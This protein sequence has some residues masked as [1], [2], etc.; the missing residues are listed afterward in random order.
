MDLVREVAY[1]SGVAELISRL[2]AR[3]LGIA[4]LPSAF[5]RPLAADDPELTLVPVIDGPH[6]VEYL[7]WNRFNPSPATRALLD[8]LGVRPQA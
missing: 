5:I 4:L 2:V 1:E 7:A 3:G 6:R 8:V